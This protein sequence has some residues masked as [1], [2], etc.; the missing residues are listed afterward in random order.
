MWLADLLR[1]PVFAP[2]PSA[3]T[4][5]VQKS[6]LELNIISFIDRDE[7][8][9]VAEPVNSWEVYVL[10]AASEGNVR[11]RESRDKLGGLVLNDVHKDTFCK[12]PQFGCTVLSQ[13]HEG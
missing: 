12:R 5:S 10:L 6:E 7:V 3:T 13:L 1:G 11:I 8:V 4:C 2:S 9:V